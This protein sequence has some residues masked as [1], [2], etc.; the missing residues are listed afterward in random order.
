[1]LYEYGFDGGDEVN[2]FR[3]G[4][5]YGWFVVILGI[6]YF[7]VI[8]LFFKYYKGMVNFIV[9]WMFLI[10]FFLMV[11]YYSDSFGVLIGKVLVIVFK[12]KVLYSLDFLVFLVV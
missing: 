8:I 11:Y 3:V 5:N 7:G 10:V 2:V 1:M 6:D 4:V 9:D 12:V